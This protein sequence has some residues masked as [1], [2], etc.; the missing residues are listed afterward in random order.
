MSL[1][2]AGELSHKVSISSASSSSSNEV[3]KVRPLI[4]VS[5]FSSRVPKVF[6]ALPLT[7][8][9]SLDGCRTS[10]YFAAEG[11]FHIYI[12]TSLEWLSYEKPRVRIER[13][14]TFVCCYSGFTRCRT[15]AV[16]VCVPVSGKCPTKHTLWAYAKIQ[17]VPQSFLMFLELTWKFQKLLRPVHMPSVLICRMAAHR[18]LLRLQARYQTTIS[19][20]KSVAQQTMSH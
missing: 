17:K 2:V 19:M 13:S 14:S 1:F 9:W 5:V 18:P 7:C 3:G 8:F 12:I 20:S 11:S 16:K 15:H 4:N 6:V 10:I